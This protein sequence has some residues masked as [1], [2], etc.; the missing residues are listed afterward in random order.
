MSPESTRS[1]TKPLCSAARDKGESNGLKKQ[2]TQLGEEYSLVTDYTSML[3]VS[4]VAMENEQIQ[5]NNVDRVRR[6]RTAQQQRNTQ[7]VKSY[8]VDNRGS[9]PTGDKGTFKNKRSPGIGGGSGPVG[10]AFVGLA[11]LLGRKKKQ[12]K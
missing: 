6:E 8:R 7:P 10:F 12:N 4:E 5:R 3:V 9:N 1:R 11:M 2:V